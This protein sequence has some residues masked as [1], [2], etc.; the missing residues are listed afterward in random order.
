LATLAGDVFLPVRTF[1]EYRAR[2]QFR[3]GGE[4][5]PEVSDAFDLVSAEGPFFGE[6]QT[7]DE[8]SPADVGGWLQSYDD[9]SWTRVLDIREG[10]GDGGF[11]WGRAAMVEVVS[12]EAE[13]TTLDLWVEGTSGHS[14]PAARAVVSGSRVEITDGED[15]LLMIF[16]RRR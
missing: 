9:G 4:G 13:A 15:G 11:L 2:A 1:T 14:S 6:G 7:A 16:E 3:E 12:T 5:I 10:M 8:D